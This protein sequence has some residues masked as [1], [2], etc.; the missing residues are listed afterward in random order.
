[1]IICPFTL[2]SGCFKCIRP[3]SVHHRGWPTHNSLSD[4]HSASHVQI[5]TRWRWVLVRS[6]HHS[7]WS[8][9]TARKMLHPIICYF[10]SDLHSNHCCCQQGF[11][12]WWGQ[13]IQ[14]P[15]SCSCNEW[16][17]W[18]CHWW[19]V[20]VYSIQWVNPLSRGK[21]QCEYIYLI[22]NSSKPDIGNANCFLIWL[23]TID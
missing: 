23:N 2:F 21:L 1:M 12:K 10:D 18:F 7:T 17:H 20:A 13:A 19:M 22:S 6:L 14:D 15:C 9:F 4:K 16:D 8:K 3:L 5:T 11:L